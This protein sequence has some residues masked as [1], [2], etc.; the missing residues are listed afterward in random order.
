MFFAMKI[1]N[2]DFLL[3]LFFFVHENR[4]VKFYDLISIFW[5][6]YGWLFINIFSASL[7]CKH[8]YIFS[9]FCIKDQRNAYGKHS[10]CFKWNQY[11]KILRWKQIPVKLVFAIWILSFMFFQLVSFYFIKYYLNLKPFRDNIEKSNNISSVVIRFSIYL[12]NPYIVFP[13]S[14]VKWLK[15]RINL[16]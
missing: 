10:V 6:E 13:I 11:L 1:K 4:V 5:V 16:P 15:L 9:L 3:W 8:Y 2:L 14:N 7:C 12:K